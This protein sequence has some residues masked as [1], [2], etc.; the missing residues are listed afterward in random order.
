M[1][2]APRL[3]HNAFMKR[4]LLVSERNSVITNQINPIYTYGAVGNFKIKRE[5]IMASITKEARI[6]LEF[7]I[8]IQFIFFFEV[9]R[10]RLLSATLI[11]IKPDPK[12]PGG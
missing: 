10:N 11:G 2:T 4:L 8:L 5:A 7:F 6:K 12:I 3:T 1:T 9:G